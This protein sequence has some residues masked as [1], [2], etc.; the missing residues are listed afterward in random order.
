MAA[1]RSV[2]ALHTSVRSSCSPKAV[3]A[4]TRLRLVDPSNVAGRT[5]I[6][7]PTS[8]AWRAASTTAASTVQGR[9][10]LASQAAAVAATVR[11]TR[12]P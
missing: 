11:L 10:S 2:E 7:E 5:F 3:R 8:T 9:L 6:P 1:S 12:A 4:S